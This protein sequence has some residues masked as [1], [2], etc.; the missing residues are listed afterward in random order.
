MIWS[1]DCIF[2]SYPIL[3]VSFIYFRLRKFS[4]TFKHVLKCFKFEIFIYIANGLI[5]PGR[6]ILQFTGFSSIVKRNLKLIQMVFLSP[7][8]FGM[9]FTDTVVSE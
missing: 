5:L 1:R 3:I 6:I 2:I 9:V 4:S 7:S 8:F